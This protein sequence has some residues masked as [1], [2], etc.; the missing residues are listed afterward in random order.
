MKKFL[1]L[2]FYS[3]FL[4]LLG[5]QLNFL[6]SLDSVQ[7]T[8]GDTLAADEIRESLIGSIS[9]YEGEYSIYYEDFSDKWTKFKPTWFTRAYDLWI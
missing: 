2:L 8:S 4:L 5:R 9:E 6:P 3:F 1:I 7:K